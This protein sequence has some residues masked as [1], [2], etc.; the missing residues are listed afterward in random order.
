M[1]TTFITCYYYCKKTGHIVRD[2]KR[3]LNREYEMEKSGK[4]NRERNK[5]WCS[6]R[7]T[8]G[9]SDMQCFQQMGKSEKFKNRRQKKGVTCTIARVIQLNNAFSRR[10]AV[11]VKIVLLLMV[12][13]AKN[14]KPIL[15]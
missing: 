13:I 1:S 4:F 12:E 9:H 8:N 5:K 2:C 11:N 7:Q 10:V 3:K 15:S 6:Y 14:V